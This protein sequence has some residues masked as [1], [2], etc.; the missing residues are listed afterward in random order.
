MEVADDKPAQAHFTDYSAVSIGRILYLA[1]VANIGSLLFGYDAGAMS[2]FLSAINNIA[3]DDT[4][5]NN[6]FFRY[7]ANNDG[8]YGFVTAGAA[9]GASFTYV[10]LLIFGNSLPK[11]DEI[12]L[13]AFLYFVGALFESEAG[14]ATW[15]KSG[16]FSSSS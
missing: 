13:S 3:E 8:I 6:V 4:D 15:H 9:I 10:L 16:G 1:F 11:K 14:D 7:V 2:T 5:T 12:M